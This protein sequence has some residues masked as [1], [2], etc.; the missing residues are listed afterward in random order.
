MELKIDFEPEVKLF[1][2]SELQKQ[3]ELMMNAAQ[4][5]R[6][7]NLLFCTSSSIQELNKTYRGQDKPTDILSFGYDSPDEPLGDLALCLEVAQAQATSF[8]LPVAEELLRLLAHGLVHL[9][10]YDHQSDEEEA[11]MLQKECTLLK[12]I[13][14][15][16]LYP[17]E[18]TKA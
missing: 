10:G 5:S 17:G 1:E 9:L 7:V 4:I 16:H 8:G 3:T 18:G 2:C 13:N 15:G 6:E 12:V 14:L 11:E